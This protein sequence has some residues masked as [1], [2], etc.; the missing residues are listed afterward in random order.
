MWWKCVQAKMANLEEEVMAL[1][2]Q[3]GEMKV[4]NDTLSSQNGLLSKVLE[5]KDDQMAVLQEGAKVEWEF[6]TST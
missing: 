4:Q 2:S 6:S 5:F 3:L 1:K